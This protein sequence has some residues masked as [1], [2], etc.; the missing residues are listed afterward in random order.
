ML[1][2]SNIRELHKYWISL[3]LWKYIETPIIIKFIYYIIII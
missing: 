1:I 2:L 3:R